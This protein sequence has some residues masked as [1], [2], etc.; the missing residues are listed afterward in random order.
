MIQACGRCRRLSREG[1]SVTAEPESADAS[2]GR[3]LRLALVLYG[4]V[5]L[6]V[7]MHGASKEIH[8]LVRTSA[9]ADDDSSLSPSEECYRELLARKADDDGV[10]TRVVVD[11]VAGTSAGGINGVGFTAV[12]W[13]V[14]ICEQAGA[15]VTVRPRRSRRPTGSPSTPP[16]PAA[17]VT[18]SRGRGAV[19]LHPAARRSQGRLRPLP[20]RRADA[21]G[22]VESGG[23]APA[24]ERPQRRLGGQR[25]H[26]RGVGRPTRKRPTARG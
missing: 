16:L 9:V 19:C 15:G 24:V 20:R 3:E 25:R 11:T 7:Y 26:G 23:A 13:T 5:S 1:G 17:R 6:A 10:G 2:G 21:A 4:G 8:R 22:R 14:D 18:V 12:R